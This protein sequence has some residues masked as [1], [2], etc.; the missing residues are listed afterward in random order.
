MQHERVVGLVETVHRAIH[1]LPVRELPGIPPLRPA[2]LPHELLDVR[3]RAVPRDR[4]QR[5][6]VRRRCD[7]RDRADFRIRNFALRKRGTDL[8]QALER[9]GDAHFLARG[10]RAD[11]ALP[12]EPLR[13]VH[14][15]VPLIGFAAVVLADETQEAVGRRVQVAP[16]LGDLGFE[17]HER[18]LLRGERCGRE[19][20]D[21]CVNRTS[22]GFHGGASNDWCYVQ[23]RRPKWDAVQ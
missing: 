3:G 7:A 14:E 2:V 20:S 10:Q 5:R 15:A 4:E 16:E 1:E 9:A 11:A 18:L 22:G 8:R 23:Y 12:V 17:V 21:G 19:R 13:G 6:L